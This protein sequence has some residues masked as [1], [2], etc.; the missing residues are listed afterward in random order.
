M[1]A[2]TISHVLKTNS[3]AI[4][5]RWLLTQARGRDPLR[6]GLPW[7]PFRAIAWLEQVLKPD[8]HL[9]EWG[10]G[11]STIFFSR[12]VGQLVSVEHDSFWYAAVASAMSTVRPRSFVYL[13]AEPEAPR[14]SARHGQHVQ[15]NQYVSMRPE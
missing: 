6:I 2:L 12:R 8:M 9:F 1:R 7:L 3:P 4:V 15:S 10:S 5:F 14:N 13:L 11:G